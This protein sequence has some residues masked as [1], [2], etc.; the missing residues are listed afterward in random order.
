MTD[1]DLEELRRETERTN[2]LDQPDTPTK[3]KSFVD[4]LV[5]AMDDV[6]RGDASHTLSVYDRKLAAVIH[7]LE[8]DEDRLQDVG[9]ALREQLGRNDD[10]EVERSDV[11]RMALRVGLQEADEELMTEARKAHAQRA[12]DQF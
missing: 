12:A 1:P 10:G 6:E 4:V 3:S 2:R 8:R 7:A 9:A 11:L 5:E